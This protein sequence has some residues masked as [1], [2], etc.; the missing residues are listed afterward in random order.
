MALPSTARAM[1]SATSPTN[2]GW[3]RVSPPPISGSAGSTRAIAAN[4]LKN[5]SSGPNM[6]EGRTITASGVAASTD[7]SPMA[8]A[9]A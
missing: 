5:A 6:I 1:A 9:R 3:N 8:L 4:L 7:F 2:T